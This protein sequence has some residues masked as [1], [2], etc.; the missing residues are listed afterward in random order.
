M[1]TI[2]RLEGI[3]DHVKTAHDGLMQAK[4]VSMALQRLA[5][6]PYTPAAM[7]KVAPGFEA[8]NAAHGALLLLIRDLRTDG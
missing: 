3:L 2:E 5:G 6:V 1:T 8:I 4:N 7:R